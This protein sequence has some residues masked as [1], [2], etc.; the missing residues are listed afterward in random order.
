MKL[1]AAG[2]LFG[3]L[4]CGGTLSASAQEYYI[5]A[6]QGSDENEGTSEDAPFQSFSTVN[7]MVLGPG[8]RVLL[9]RGD[10][11]NQRLEIHGSG[12]ADQWIYVGPYGSLEDPAPK[13]SMNNG[14]DDICLLA[15]DISPEKITPLGLNYIH[16]DNLHLTD[17][18]IGVYFRYVMTRGNEGVRV[19][20]CQFDNMDC[21]PVMEAIAYEKDANKDYI[22]QGQVTK[23]KGKLRRADFNGGSTEYVWPT[24]IM[25]GGQSGTVNADTE[26]SVV[27][28]MYIDQNIFNRCINGVVG[29]FYWNQSENGARSCKHVTKNWRITNCSITGTVNGIVALSG[30]DGG[31]DCKSADG[32]GVMQNLHVT[33][34]NDRNFQLGV[35]GGIIEG[36]Q[37]FLI[38]S[39]LFTDIRNNGAPDGCGFDFEANCYNMTLRNSI[40]AFNDGQGVLMMDNGTGASRDIL[41]TGNLFYDNLKSTDTSFYRWDICIWKKNENH[42]NIVVRNNRFIGHRY[43]LDYGGAAS[44]YEYAAIGEGLQ[45]VKFSG[46]QVQQVEN[47]TDLPAFEDIV[48]QM[49]LTEAL[50]TPQL[51]QISNKPGTVVA[52]PSLSLGTDSNAN[53][54]ENVWLY[55]AGIGALSVAAALAVFLV[56][57]R[58]K[59][60]GELDES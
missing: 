37:N 47:G 12:K 8:D 43:L 42:R 1:L 6:T 30:A 18:R 34:G 57:K 44:G 9:K 46:N 51:S 55:A 52:P 24:A 58:R 14:E 54:F 5:S 23:K 40:F 41:L 28:G 21:P 32:F 7:K 2:I 26:E 25:I 45:G 16:V 33:G 53:R 11:W 10:E 17:S 35:T 49:G 48:E 29:I 27:S 36:S 20:N 38:D 4:F 22:I 19:T 13:I 60:K 3:I 50:R 15:E 39:C 56:L 31:W 59:K